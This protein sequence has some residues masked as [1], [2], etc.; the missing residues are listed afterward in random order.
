MGYERMG[1]SNLPVEP[2]LDKQVLA[3]LQALRLELRAIRR[4]LDEFCGAYLNAKF[5]FGD[6]KGD[7]WPR[8]RH[9]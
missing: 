1:N 5:R 4:V 2:P 3:E 8:R 7:R 6:G 9:G